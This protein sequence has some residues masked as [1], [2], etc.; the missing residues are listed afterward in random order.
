MDSRRPPDELQDETGVWI[1]SGNSSNSKPFARH[2]WVWRLYHFLV[3]DAVA[4]Q[5]PTKYKLVREF[6]GNSL[7]IA[8]DIGCGPGVFT[9]YMSLRAKHLI[10]ADIDRDSLERVKSRHRNLQNVDFAVTVVDSL[11]FSDDLLDTVLF[12][13]VLEH[14]EDDGAALREIWRVLRPNGRLVVSVPVPP[15]EVNEDSEWGHKREG[16]ELPAIVHLLTIN[17]FKVEKHA[18]AE[19]KFSRRAARVVGWW[20]Q[21]I[22][23]PAPIVLSWIAYLDHFLDPNKTITGNHTPATVLVLARKRSRE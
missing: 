15:G 5:R 2:Y 8:A 13:E 16:Y 22:R 7:G 11:P 19:F 20:R 9:R 21:T 6:L 4:I 10:G 18:F 3:A 12:L 14:L 17:G 1:A 23:L